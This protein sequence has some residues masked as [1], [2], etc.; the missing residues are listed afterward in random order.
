M[1]NACDGFGVDEEDVLGSR[2][3]RK[4]QQQ[5]QGAT[6]V[7]ATGGRRR[8][9][10]AGGPV[11]SESPIGSP[12][13]GHHHHHH[14]ISP[15]VIGSGG[16]GLA[17]VRTK[18]PPSG[19]RGLQHNT[20]LMDGLGSPMAAAFDSPPMRRV[21]NGA[22]GAGPAA[23]P[24]FSR[25]AGVTTGAGAGVVQPPRPPHDLGG[26]SGPGGL[27][28]SDAFGSGRRQHASRLGG[29]MGHHTD[30]TVDAL[31][32]A[33]DRNGRSVRGG[34]GGG[35]YDEEDELL[36]PKAARD[37]PPAPGG[38]RNG[39]GDAWGAGI[40]RLML[41]PDRRGGFGQQDLQ[42]A[43]T[44]PIVPPSKVVQQQRAAAAAAAGP[45]LRPQVMTLG[46][47][48]GDEMVDLVYDPVLNCYYDHKTNKYYELKH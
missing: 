20:L 12:R 9:S 28:Q 31:L 3:F 36:F 23:S 38:G 11:P 33:T 2:H 29:G 47:R 48:G 27:H 41:P 8:S 6:A 34:G 46:G 44:P 7:T 14:G 19:P 16:G 42:R 22:P 35:G 18:V 13:G 25:V 15:A 40:D 5:Q 1:L 30:T 26:V 45:Q 39:D 32:G 37:S 10:G 17:P 21:G 24:Q 4:P 43:F